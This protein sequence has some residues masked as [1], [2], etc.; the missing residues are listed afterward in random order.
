MKKYFELPVGMYQ[1]D[2][3]H[4]NTWP[5]GKPVKVKHRYVFIKH[6]KDWFRQ[7]F[8]GGS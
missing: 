8:K 4:L 7:I 6:M 2:G 3:R 5:D 1:H